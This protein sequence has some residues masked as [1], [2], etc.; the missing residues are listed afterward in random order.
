MA[1]W[2]HLIR[3]VAKEDLAIHLGQLVDT[4]RDVGKDT[5]E[6]REVKAYHIN[7]SIFDGVVTSVIYTVERVC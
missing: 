5:A 6:G 4:S 1:R 3:F 7:G 2:T